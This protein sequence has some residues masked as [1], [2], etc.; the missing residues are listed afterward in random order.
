MALV[1]GWARTP[2]LTVLSGLLF[3]VSLWP[4][5]FP[6]RYVVGADG[7]DIDYYVW[8]RRVPWTRFR[9][10][11][12]LP[13][14]VMLTPFRRQQAMERYRALL[15]PCP[16]NRDEVI[17]ALPTDLFRR[18]GAARRGGCRDDD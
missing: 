5:Y 14:A 18:D 4:F 9:A 1:H 17:A 15:L 16:R 3:L 12:V 8:R 10:F 6:V 11:V 2:L 7:L 13:G